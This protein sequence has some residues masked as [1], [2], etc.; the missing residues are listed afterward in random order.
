MTQHIAVS[1]SLVKL[2]QSFLPHISTPGTFEGGYSMYTT[3]L[4]PYDLLSNSIT[5]LLIRSAH[6][7]SLGK[8]H[9][10]PSIQVAVRLRPS[11][12]LRDQPRNIH[13]EPCCCRHH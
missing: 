7:L 5:S 11:A 10:P 4:A 12:S 1:T 8:T 6:C 3:S 9:C 2:I 13:L